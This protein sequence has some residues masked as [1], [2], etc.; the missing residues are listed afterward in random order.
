MRRI[1][2]LAEKSEKKIN[3]NIQFIGMTAKGG[4]GF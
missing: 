2:L 4:D 3:V 1:I